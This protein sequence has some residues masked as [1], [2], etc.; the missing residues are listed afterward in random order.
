MDPVHDE[1]YFSWRFNCQAKKEPLISAGATFPLVNDDEDDMESIAVKA[2]KQIIQDVKNIDM[3]K[4]HYNI[5]I[6]KDIIKESYSQNP[7]EGEEQTN[8]KINRIPKDS[9][10]IPYD[11]DIHQMKPQ[12]LSAP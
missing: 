7:E 1:C 4:G 3:D 11:I 10:D 6:N 12:R 5:S 9:P 2:I 8:P